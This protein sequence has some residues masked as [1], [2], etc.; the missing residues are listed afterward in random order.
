MTGSV[1]DTE[2]ILHLGAYQYLPRQVKTI[3]YDKI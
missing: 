1:S 3:S 2:D